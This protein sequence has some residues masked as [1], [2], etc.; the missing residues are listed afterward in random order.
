MPDVVRVIRE[1]VARA[2]AH[3]DGTIGVAISGGADSTALADAAIAVLGAARVV[4]VHVDHGLRGAAAAA[5]DLRA[6]RAV[7][8]GAEVRVRRAEITG[9][10]EAAARRARYALLDGE[11]DLAAILTAHTARDQAETVL[12]RILRGTG[13]AGLAGIARRRGRYLRPLLATTR[14]EI[15]QYIVARALDVSHD[16][17]NDSPRFLRNRIRTDLMRSLARENPRIEAALCR[18]ADQ[19]RAWRRALVRDA[20][21]LVRAAARGAS[22]DAPTLAAAPD[23]VLGLAIARITR[24]PLDEPHL[25]AAIRLIRAKR[26]GTR[27]IDLP[28]GRL[29]REYDDVRVHEH[30]HE[31]V[32]QHEHELQVDCEE[33]F[34]VRLVQPGDRMRPTRLKGRSRKLSDLYADAKVPRRLRADARVVIRRADNVILWA[35]HLGPAHEARITVAVLPSRT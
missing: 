33:P 24:A 34:D 17:T 30:E 18:L 19:A 1:R 15:E 10:G 31:H 12:M 2:L 7:A 26:A 35:E 22:Y 23:A 27:T 6:V 28:G 21:A 3:V 32:H 13:P 9:T 25:R 14:A 8:A 20:R 29:T 4:L 16:E 5:R 11:R